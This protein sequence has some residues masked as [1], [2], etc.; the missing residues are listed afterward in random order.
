MIVG[1]GLLVLDSWLESAYLDENNRV[2]KVCSKGF[3]FP[4]SGLLFP[5]GHIKLSE[6]NTGRGKVYESFLLKIAGILLVNT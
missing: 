5:T 6:G 3:E 1:K 4:P 2:E